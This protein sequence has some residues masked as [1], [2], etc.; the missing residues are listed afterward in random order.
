VTASVATAASSTAPVTMNFVDVSIAS[1]S[2]P[3]EIEHGD[4]PG[5]GGVVVDG[6]VRALRSRNTPAP[7][8]ACRVVA[9]E[10]VA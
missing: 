6:E 10:V 2:I 4:L 3:F 7:A 8:G 5:I 9:A 1:R